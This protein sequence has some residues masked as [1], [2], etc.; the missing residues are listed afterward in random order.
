[1]NDNPLL[2][3]VLGGLFGQVTGQRT[4]G[5]GA[6]TDQGGGLGGLLA[7]LAGAGGAHQP[8]G[9][10]AGLHADA[11]HSALL[12]SLLPLAMRWVQGSGGIGAVLEKFRQQGLGAQAQSWVST[13]ANQPVD[14]QAVQ[15]VVGQEH[16]QE[17][18]QRLGV[19]PQQVAQGFAEIM[20]QMVDQLTPQGHVPQQA[21]DALAQGA[22]KLEQALQGLQQRETQSS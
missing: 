4:T 20:P 2:G 5:A 10:P 12:A 18:A 1:M 22:R 3:Q 15:Q 14:S 9:A 6:P 13:G 21:D 8:A 16:L 11:S 19:P 7:G 17:L